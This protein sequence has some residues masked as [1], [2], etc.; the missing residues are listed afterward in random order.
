MTGLSRRGLLLGG[1]LGAVGAFGIVSPAPWTWAAEGSVIGSGAGLDPKT[2]W[3]DE[4]DAVVAGGDA[5][6]AG[7]AAVVAA[8]VVAAAVVAAAVVAAVAVTVVA[9]V[10]AVAA[11]AIAVVAAGTVVAA[12][13]LQRDWGGADP[14]R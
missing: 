8:A 3:D 9:A 12:G 1:G 5:V 6:V 14:E 7:D 10:T 11:V 13:R 2:V 4:A